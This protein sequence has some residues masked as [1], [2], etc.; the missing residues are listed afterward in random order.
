MNIEKFIQ[1]LNTIDWES[2][3]IPE[4]WREWKSPKEVPRALI[5][6]AKS[7]YEEPI[8][9]ESL[10]REQYSE[11]KDAEILSQILNNLSLSP[12][13]NLP[14]APS[15]CRFVLNAVGNDHSGEYFSVI[16]AALPFLIEIAL[17]GNNE[18]TRYY[19]AEI[20]DLFCFTF[21]SANGDKQIEDFVIT[22]ILNRRNDFA[23]IAESCQYKKS[24]YEEFVESMDELIEERK[25]L[26][27]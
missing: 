15:A 3:E 6:L 22:S 11:P 16:K 7:G 25:T 9:P 5:Y 27:T 20:L 2:F 18:Y 17:D 24:F 23:K 1:E 13:N 26:R 12:Y 10:A 4:D 21:I 19:A 14:I 8:T